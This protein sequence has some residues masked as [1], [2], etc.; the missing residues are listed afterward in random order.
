MAAYRV[1]HE[2]FSIMDTQNRR[3]K[4]TNRMTHKEMHERE[5]PKKWITFTFYSPVIRRITNLFKD[6]NIKIAFRTTNTIQQQLSTRKSN[7]TNPSDIYKIQCNNCNKTYIGQT[8]G[9]ISTRFKEHIRYIKYNNPQ[10]AYAI[11]TLQNKHEYGPE[12][13]T[14]QLVKQCI[15]GTRMSC[16]ENSYIQMHHIRGTLITEQQV[17][18]LNPLYSAAN[19]ARLIPGN[20]L[21]VTDRHKEDQQQ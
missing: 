19:T 18:E 14:L 16:W 11:H 12:K 2:M 15:K 13:E 3:R 1:V 8:G 9:S 6:T 10:S 21:A 4:L 20:T 17:N 7:Q 5:K